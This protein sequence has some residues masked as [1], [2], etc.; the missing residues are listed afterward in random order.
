MKASKLRYFLFVLLQ[1]G[2]LKKL[3][4]VKCKMQDRLEKQLKT[5]CCNIGDIGKII[6]F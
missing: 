6:S 1:D 2:L 5:D 4:F 3:L